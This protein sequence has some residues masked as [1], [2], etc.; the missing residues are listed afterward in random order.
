MMGWGWK[1]RDERRGRRGRRAGLRPSA[2]RKR[3]SAIREKRGKEKND[4]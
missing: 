2:R 1:K 3:V 4:K